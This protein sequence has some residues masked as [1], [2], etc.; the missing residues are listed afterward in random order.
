MILWTTQDDASYKELL[1]KGVFR[2]DLRAEGLPD[3]KAA[4]DWLVDQ[5]IERIGP[6]PRG[7]VYPIWAWFQWREKSKKPDLGH[8]RRNCGRKGK[9]FVRLELE[10]PDKDVLL[11]DFELWHYVLR[12]SALTYSEEEYD[13]LE[14]KRFSLSQ[15]E[16][17]KI[18]ENTWRTIFDLSPIDTD[19]IRRGK[20]IQATFWELRL[21]YVRKA[22]PFV[23]NSWVC[24]SRGEPL[25]SCTSNSSRSDK[26]LG[27]L[28]SR[29]RVPKPRPKKIRAKASETR[30]VD[31]RVTAGIP[32]IFGSSD[33]A[34]LRRIFEDKSDAIR[35]FYRIRSEAV[36]EN[37]SAELA[38]P[39]EL[40]ASEQS[41]SIFTPEWLLLEKRRASERAIAAWQ[42]RKTA[43][44]EEKER[45]DSPNDRESGKGKEEHEQ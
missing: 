17:Q 21:E 18:K 35:Q 41:Q 4:Y 19:W 11:S 26:G 1:K 40:L 3:F 15:E 30:N 16:Y 29:N 13:A 14:R 43:T 20:S 37:P 8:L 24:D 22:T 39:I 23:S 28:K 27:I 44:S 25:V 5:M 9:R 34:I 6:K 32:G 38:I 42:K 2:C 31:K 10:I 12:N 7:V 45:E 36:R 33:K